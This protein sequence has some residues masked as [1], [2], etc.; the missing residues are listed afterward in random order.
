M[1]KVLRLLLAVVLAGSLALTGCS[2]AS[3]QY[4]ND[5]DPS[6]EQLIPTNLS[7]DDL[8]QQLFDH[9]VVQG[10][11]TFNQLVEDPSAMGLQRP[12]P[13]LGD[14][15]FDKYKTDDEYYKVFLERLNS[16]DYSTL[17]QTQQNTFDTMQDSL[18][19]TLQ[20]EPL[21][22]YQEPLRP[23]MGIQTQLPTSLLEYNFR[24]TQD[25]DDYISLLNDFPRY[26][27][28]IIDFEQEKA[29]EGLLM[30]SE[31]FTDTIN[32]IQQFITT[33][34]S[35]PIVTAFNADVDAGTDAFGTLTQDQKSSYEQQDLDAVTNS[36]MPA[37]QNLHDSMQNLSVQAT[38]GT[39][40]ASYPQGKQFYNLCMKLDG[41]TCTPDAAETTLDQHLSSEIASI[42]AGA[43]Y[44]T[45]AKAS[46]RNADIPTDPAGILTYLQNAMQND[47]P[48]VGD[49]SYVVN[50]VPA[51]LPNSF[52]LAFYMTP[53]VDDAQHNV[54]YYYPDKAKSQPELYTT[55]SHEGF[56]GHLYQTY[57]Y[58]L[59][60]PSDICKVLTSSAYM[61]GWAIYSQ[62]QAFA[63]EYQDP[64][65]ANAQAAYLRFMYELDARVD[66][67]VNYQG[68]SEDQVSDYMSQY[69]MQ[70][71]A[72][73]LYDTV[74]KE[75]MS[76]L[77]YGLGCT[78]FT[79]LRSQA[80]QKLGD[81]FNV[82]QFHE[83]ILD[84]GPVSFDVLEKQF[85]VWLASQ[86]SSIEQ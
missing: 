86:P 39:T 56:P 80:E 24:T 55:L 44:L 78:E 61:E 31:S 74:L 57:Y 53:P 4:A 29:N 42:S 30:N 59:S 18:E 7:F 67:G 28:Q 1:N 3:D 47:Y 45:G 12:T 66:I 23:S 50:Q 54:I 17:T 72:Q 15:S 10:T 22:Y 6:A 25:I 79:N 62:T 13:T 58:S 41:F 82:E 2:C 16:F 63:Y 43:D 71:T 35:S 46:S 21:Y 34:S 51:G 60:N 9:E 8:A 5:V 33:P 81:S 52:A 73:S 36:V 76:Y 26:F 48:S 84:A 49:V 83:A 27:Q 77:P 69:S 11:L 32:E 38:S 19:Y 65:E 14:Y 37:F 85:N 20:M 70:S 64:N 75:P 68:W 40:I